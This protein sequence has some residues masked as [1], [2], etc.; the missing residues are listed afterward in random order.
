MRLFGFITA[1]FV[2]T[3]VSVR[4][5]S[6]QETKVKWFGHAAFSI[7]TPRGKVLLIDPWLSNP[8]NP[9]AKDG[10]DPLAS[11]RKVDYILITHGHRDHVGDAVE[12]AKKTGAALVCNPELAGNLV[13]LAGFPEKQAATDAIMGIGGEIQ[14]ADGEV[15]VAMTPAVHSSSVYNPKAGPTDAERAY[16][17]NPA[18]FVIMIKGGPVIYHSGDTA[19]FKDMETIGEQYQVDLALLNIGGHFGME[20]RMAARAAKSV[21]AALAVPQHYAT[22][23]GIAQNSN[24]FASEL[25]RLR[26]PFYE[27]KPG[28]TLTYHG[29]QRVTE[30]RIIR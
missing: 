3:F 28:E 11:V 9:E 2:L 30:T 13:K 7:T 27:M 15:T 10:K 5:A 16:G 18:G 17:G 19:Y 12:I 26:I 6:A 4:P 1:L 29:R 23:P 22:F 25:K 8:S 20:P 14:I 21:R 24:D